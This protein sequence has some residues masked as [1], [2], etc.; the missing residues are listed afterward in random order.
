MLN[1]LK[2]TWAITF[3][4]LK[5][6]SRDK[7]TFGLVVMIPIIQLLLF[8]FAINTNVRHIP[9]GVVDLSQTTLSRFLIKEI[10]A[11]QVVDFT[12]SYHSTTE[13][14]KGITKGDIRAAFIIPHDMPS[15]FV[16][17]RA[18]NKLDNKSQFETEIRPLAQWIVDGSDT[19]IA[20]AI[21]G[22]RNMPMISYDLFTEEANRKTP[23][24][25]VVEYYNPDQRTVVNIVPGL[26]GIILTMTMVMFTSAAIVREKEC[27][28]LEFLISTPVRPIELMVGKILPYILIGLIQMVLI[29]GLGYY[30]FNV[31]INGSH[32]LIFVT[33]L[34]FILTS[35]TL[36]LLISTIAK[37]Q[38]Q[39][40]QMTIFVLLPSILLSG[41][42]FPYEGMP[43]I[44]QW[45]AEVF[46]A[47]H[48][49]RMIRGVV[50][51]QA[52]LTDLSADI[53]WNLAFIAVVL[54]IA[55]LR[56]KK[57]LD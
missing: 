21:K 30:I 47:T 11:T 38:L 37:T 31:P 14:E 51:R 42:M 20:S 4:E 17:M 50:L 49:I 25:E 54:L 45:I 48:F 41:F 9:V 27:G 3:K 34:L 33:S 52:N 40:M 39:S 22:L 36:G 23:N 43:K 56:F 55:S 10:K 53:Y 16:Q 46:P 13:A 2:R 32:T 8:G 24:F 35:L 26:V 29:L 7:L 44:A 19:I 28:N 1:V 57:R 12:K 6:L 15:R 5:Q 18:F